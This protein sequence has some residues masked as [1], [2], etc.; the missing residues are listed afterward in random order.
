MPG[1][2]HISLRLVRQLFESDSGIRKP[3]RVEVK[4]YNIESQMQEQ[5][6]HR[7]PLQNGALLG[8]TAS[9]ASER[10]PTRHTG[11][12]SSEDLNCCFAG[13]SAGLPHRNK[14]ALEVQ[15]CHPSDKTRDQC[16][17]SFA[18][19]ERD[20]DDLALRSR[21][22]TKRNAAVGV[23]GEVGIPCA[24]T[25]LAGFFRDARMAALPIVRE[26]RRAH[27]LVHSLQSRGEDG[28]KLS[29]LR[30][31]VLHREVP[32][33]HVHGG[34]LPSNAPSILVSAKGSQ[35]LGPQ[36]QVPIPPEPLEGRVGGAPAVHVGL[37]AA[38]TLHRSALGDRCLHGE[39]LKSGPLGPGDGEEGKLRKDRVQSSRPSL[40]RSRPPNRRGQDLCCTYE[41]EAERAFLLC[42]DSSIPVFPNE[43]RCVLYEHRVLL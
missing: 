16:S 27:S 39:K 42:S 9:A 6:H 40:H 17:P 4:G 18:P 36:P 12:P 38:Q 35:L 14:D 10:V 23:F 1:H 32:R 25:L 31:F 8:I 33:F 11:T 37:K 34:Q 22:E 29:E 13:L 20:A 19:D 7:M 43:L 41:D 21:F 24:A 5:M 15:F 28:S 26:G 30:L 3:E 2:H